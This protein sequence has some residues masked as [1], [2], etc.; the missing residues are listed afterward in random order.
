MIFKMERK[1]PYKILEKYETMALAVKDTGVSSTNIYHAIRANCHA[2]GYYWDK[3]HEKPENR[4]CNKCKRDLPFNTD[5]FSPKKTNRFNLAHECKECVQMG[6]AKYKKVVVYKM[7]SLNPP[8]II[9]KYESV[10]EASEQ[11]RTPK[12]SIYKGINEKKKMNGFYWAKKV[13]KPEIETAT[14]RQ[15]KK[16]KH[17]NGMFFDLK[18]ANQMQGQVICNTCTAE[19]TRSYRK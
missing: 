16:E 14:C 8:V 15:C 13:T 9:K 4:I 12:S 17:L 3:E 2:G 5:F 7:E 6:F 18:L 11:T 10:P 1:P 19:N